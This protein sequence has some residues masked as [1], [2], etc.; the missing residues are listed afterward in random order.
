MRI[1][2]LSGLVVFAGVMATNPSTAQMVN[3][4]ITDSVTVTGTR[5]EARRFDMPESTGALGSLLIEE[6][7]PTHPSEIMERIAGVHQVWLAGDHHTTVIRQ[8]I[9]FNPVYLY[10]EN[11]VPTRSTGFFETNALFDVNMPQA[12]RVEITKGP[13]TAL[14]GSDAIGGVINVMTPLPAKENGGAISVEGSTRDYYRL[15][16]TGSVSTGKQGFRADINLS[17][18]EGWRDDTGSDRQLGNFTWAI[19]PSDRVSIQNVLL[20]AKVSQDSSGSN[21]S[22]DDWENNPTLNKA[23]IAARNVESVRF[24]SLIDVQMDDALLSLVPYFRYNRVELLPAF[25]LGFDPHQ[26]NV[27]GQ[28]IGVLAKYR[29]NISPTFRLIFGVDVDYSWGGRT[30]EAIDLLRIDGIYESFDVIGTVYDFSVKALSLAPY[31]HA[32]WQ[33]A[34]RLRLTAG[35]RFDYA[36]YE[37]ADNLAGVTDPTT[38]HQRPEDQDVDFNH[39]TPKLGFTYDINDN[40]NAFVSYR[41]GFRMPTITQLFRPGRSTESTSLKPVKSE[42]YEVGLRGAIGARVG[43]EIAGY[44]MTNRDDILVFTDD[45]TGVRQIE[46]SGKTRHKGVELSLNVEVTPTL[47]FS[48]AYA[49]NHHSFVEWMPR[50]GADLSGNEINRAPKDVANVLLAWRPDWLNGGRLEIEYQHLGDYYLDD[51]NTHTYKGHDLVHVRGNIKIGKS[52]DVFVRVHNLLNTRFATNG[53][54]NGFVGEELKPGQTRTFYGGVSA[55]F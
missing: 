39:F 28:S 25:V 54:Y 20:L 10:L 42:S 30:D 38:L 5:E 26:Y 34:G 47:L 51:N 4:Q 24:H 23:P 6:V 14:Y 36:K 33:I 43:F 27:H 19:D 35:L 48:V 53:R 7:L 31:I 45:E 29:H 8:P 1:R 22:R 18:D 3:S 15:L 9:N 40:L 11:G 32:E 37:Y 21:L 2:N 12:S 16:A 17:K 52:V 44:I 50:T 49:Y 13:G 55:V 41:Q 46:N